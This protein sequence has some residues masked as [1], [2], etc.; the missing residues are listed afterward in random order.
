MNKKM[1]TSMLF[2]ALLSSVVSFSQSFDKL[3]KAPV[4]IAYLT[5][6]KFPSP[7][8]KVVYGRPQKN[9]NKVFGDQ[10]PYG[11]IWHTERDL[12]NKSIPEYQEHTAVVTAVV[13]YGLAN[14]NHVLSREGMFTN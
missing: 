5:T 1:I 7:L 10:I 2:C 9:S 12:Y 11:E 13:V 4:D 14:L 8:I 6:R 3:D